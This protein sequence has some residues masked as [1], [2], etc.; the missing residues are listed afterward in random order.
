MIRISEFLAASPDG[1]TLAEIK[2]QLKLT[3][4]SVTSSLRRLMAKLQVQAVGEIGKRIYKR[5][6][7]RFSGA[8]IL[9]AMQ[10]AA[11]AKLMSRTTEV[12]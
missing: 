10:S 12:A 9:A 1:A 6:T 7:V 4:D 2:G 3:E 8:E 11:R 5:R